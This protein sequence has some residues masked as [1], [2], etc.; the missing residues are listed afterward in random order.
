MKDSDIMK[1]LETEAVELKRNLNDTFEKEVVA[2]LNS[3]NGYI[4]LGVEDNGEICGINK[5]DETLKKISDVISTSI[6]PNP[7]ELIKVKAILEKDKFII[8]VSI[9]KGNSL[10]YISK[11]G[12]SSKGCYTRVGTTCRSM[13]EEQI[14]KSILK[15]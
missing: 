3:H 1:Y 13:S 10:Y 7:Q 15:H 2:F 12:R 9:K 11:Y 4:Y 14:E 5:L 6:L 8:E